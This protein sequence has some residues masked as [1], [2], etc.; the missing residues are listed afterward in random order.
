MHI[1]SQ[2]GC[3]THLSMVY[4]PFTQKPGFELSVDIVVDG[5]LK[6]SAYSHG[7]G[8]FHGSGSASLVAQLKRGQIVWVRAPDPRHAS[9]MGGNNWNIF[10]GYLIQE[11]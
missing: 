10:T 1:T 3:S 11:M 8:K 5:N 9:H 6:V 7:D 2:K 4:T